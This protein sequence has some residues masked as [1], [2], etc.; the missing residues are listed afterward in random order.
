[1]TS[2]THAQSQAMARLKELLIEAGINFT[3]CVFN[4]EEGIKG[5]GPE[6][7]VSSCIT[8]LRLIELLTYTI[9]PIT[10]FTHSNIHNLIS[11]FTYAISIAEP[12]IKDFYYCFIFST[13]PSVSVQGKIS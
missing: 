13:C 4:T 5:L 8:L 11:H 7:F 6:P 2:R 9:L 1:L 3:N 10:Q 12:T